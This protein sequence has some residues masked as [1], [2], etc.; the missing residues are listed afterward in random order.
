MKIYTGFGD[1]GKTKLF[2]G[3][4]VNKDHLRIEVYGTLDELNSWLGFIIAGDPDFSIKN[5]LEI[6]QKN[7][8]SISSEI[9]AP[10][11]KD[12]KKLLNIIGKK[13]YCFLEECIDE[14]ENN[15]EPLKNFILPGGTQLAGSYHIARS[16]CR[17]AE[18]QMVKLF[19]SEKNIETN[20]VYINRLS[21][22]LFVL[23]RFANKNAGTEDNKWKN[24]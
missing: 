13:D 10:D 12:R 8:F 15:L 7:I 23:A 3:S 11:P 19:Q 4:V 24:D 9:A 1:K 16:I 22:L 14:I 18:R 5:N 21:D 17:R 2:G 6:I 20:L